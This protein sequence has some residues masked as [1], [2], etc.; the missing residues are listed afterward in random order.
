MKKNTFN[1]KEHMKQA[2]RSR[3]QDPDT[4][5]IIEGP[6]MSNFEDTL[7]E[8][9]TMKYPAVKWTMDLVSEVKAWIDRHFTGKI[10]PIPAQIAKDL[11]RRPL[12]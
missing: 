10:P 7:R 4:G 12:D 6:D 8:K 9:L 3:F 1:L 11:A 5:S 2:E